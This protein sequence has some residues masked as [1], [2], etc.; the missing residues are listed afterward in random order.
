MHKHI[1]F[2]ERRQ[3]RQAVERGGARARVTR[4]LALAGLG[5]AAAVLAT[6]ATAATRSGAVVKLHKSSLG[7]ILADSHGRTLYMWAHDKHHKS[8]CYGGCAVYW[9]ALI[10]HGKPRATGGVRKALLGT[11]RRRDGKLQVTYRGHPLY[12]FAGDTGPGQTS[13][14]GLTD[15]GG[16]WDPLTA[17]GLPAG[18]SPMESRHF[19][20]PKLAHGILR[21]KGTFDA[22]KVALRLKAGD[23]QTLQVDI[24]DDGSADFSFDRSKIAKIAVRT[25][26]GDDSVR[27]DESNGVFTDTIPTT[28]DGGSGNDT[29]AGGSG[30]ETLIGGDGNDVIDGNKGSDTALLGSGDD[31]FVWDPGDGS[32]IVEGQDGFDTMRFNGAAAAEQFTLSANGNRLRFFRDVGNVTMDTAGVELVDVNALGG[33]DLVTVNDLSGT[34]VSSVNADLAGSL[35]GT[36]GDAALDQ[37]V[38]N[39][40]AGNDAIKIGGDASGV[41]VSGLHTQVAIQHQEPADKLAVNGLGGADSIDASGL[42]ASAVAL[43]LDGGVGNDTIAG[44]Q[45]VE[46]SLGGDGNDVIDGNK[47][48]DTALMGAGDDVFV[49]DPGDGSDIVEGG[50]GRSDTLRFNG[51]AA[52]EKFDLSANGNRLR[53]FRDVG[54]VTM[55]TAG[56]ELVDVNALGGADLVTVNDL[57]GTDVASVNVDLAGSL[58]GAAGDGAVDRVVMNGTAG[59]DRIDVSGN[60]NQVTVGGLAPL[61]TI[62][63]PEATD[64]LELN[65]LEV[66]DTVNTGGL[67]AGTIQVFIDGGLIFP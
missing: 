64:H 56:V 3:A 37:V 24:R 48:N 6:A 62:S 42:A 16:R 51:A 23:S 9:P 31:V 63:N 27:I 22:D 19:Q 35:G 5:L 17:A 21:I 38:V 45:G 50:D 40:T 15:F 52:A 7:Q 60:S 14:E 65:A 10:T 54:N 55:D 44:G 11:T 36:A 57:S 66:G 33:A 41:T 8:T 28:I 47:G 26:N 30:N 32:D 49:W 43:T 46:T 53:L 39:G 18:K 25:R 20:R 34:D 67:A 4:V 2:T 13:G 59:D 29:I 12:R 1:R 61:V 58:G